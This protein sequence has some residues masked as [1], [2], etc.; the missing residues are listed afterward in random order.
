MFSFREVSFAY[1]S[2]GLLVLISKGFYIEETGPKS[3][4]SIT[5]PDFSLL[6][7]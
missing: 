2:T 1:F 6:I 5:F 4:M 3:V 7:L